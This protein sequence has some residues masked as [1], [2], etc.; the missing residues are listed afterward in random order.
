M[1]DHRDD[2][3]RAASR[4]GTQ[5]L[6]AHHGGAAMP[7]RPRQHDDGR[8]TMTTPQPA[9]TCIRRLFA[10]SPKVTPSSSSDAADNTGHRLTQRSHQQ[11]SLDE[12]FFT[13]RQRPSADVM[14]PRRAARPW[15]QRSTTSSKTLASH[16]HPLVRRGQSRKVDLSPKHDTRIGLLAVREP[17]WV[18]ARAPRL[19]ARSGS[20]SRARTAR[21][22]AGRCSR[23]RISLR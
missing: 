11:I 12:S 21:L 10:S 23:E 17:A 4:A 22:L 5:R 16:R 13:I 3:P 8:D 7:Q 19:T 20:C 2:R 14:R 18:P 1:A 15:G 9:R 6:T